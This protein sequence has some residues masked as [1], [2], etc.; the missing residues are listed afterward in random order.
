MSFS[1]L[2]DSSP[3]QTSADK[4]NMEVFALALLL[5]VAKKKKGD[6]CD[7]HISLCHPD[8]MINCHDVMTL[9]LWF[10]S[11]RIWT[12]MFHSLYLVFNCVREAPW[13]W[14][15]CRNCGKLSS[16]D[17]WLHQNDCLAV[18]NSAAWITTTWSWNDEQTES[19]KETQVVLWGVGGSAV[20]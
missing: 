17:G 14:R 9:S 13:L 1:Y 4:H 3:L 16:R 6:F 10:S 12:F 5:L 19:A 20:V 2:F 18:S 11:W 8:G 15:L 7:V